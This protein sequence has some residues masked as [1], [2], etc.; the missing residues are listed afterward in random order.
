[1]EQQLLG[2]DL[3]PT[4][5]MRNGEQLVFQCADCG[6]VVVQSSLASGRLGTCPACRHYPTTWRKQEL[7]IAGL[8]A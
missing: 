6:T 5:A 2:L 4:I 7:P 8:T 3:E 1:M